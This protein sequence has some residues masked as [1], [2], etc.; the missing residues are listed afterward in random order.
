MRPRR[1]PRDTPAVDTVRL[2]GLHAAAPAVVVLLGLAL[3]VVTAIQDF[4]TSARVLLGSLGVAGIICGLVVWRLTRNLRTLAQQLERRAEEE[5]SFRKIAG[6]LTAAGNVDQVLGDITDAATAVTRADG[7]YVEK[8]IEK[9]TTV[10]VIT[11]KGRGV[12]ALGLKVDYPG[13]LTEEI[14]K[15][16]AP[17]ILSDMSRFG[18]PMAPYVKNECAECEVLVLPLFAEAELLGAFV[19]LNSKESGRHFHEADV[20]RAKTL[21]DLASLALRRVT[22]LERERELR[23]AAEEAARLREEILG[24]VTHDLRNPIT[25][26]SLSAQLLIKDAAEEDEAREH[27]TT[28]HDAAERMQTLINDLLDAARVHG[29]RFAVK[30]VP[31]EPASIVSAACKNHATLAEAKQ[32]ALVCEAEET[33]PA[34]CGDRGRLLQVLDNLIGNAMKFTPSGG[35]IIVRCTWQGDHARFSVTDT[36]PGISPENLDQ[37]FRDFWQA[38]RTAHLGAGLGLLIAK[39]TVEAHGGEIGA[40]NDPETGG[41]CFWF[42]IPAA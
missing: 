22:T 24:V 30:K 42:T 18:T 32:L 1:S 23:R 5:G 8:I 21:G 4:R 17:L 20:H 34:I 7:V 28:I 6:I 25:T 33:M 40:N 37:L 13:S 11:S 39:G 2:G 16:G 3:L 14:I 29:G 36:G 35:R 9:T 27:L 38:G 19:L 26:I 41:A 10:E 12:P 15:S 31:V